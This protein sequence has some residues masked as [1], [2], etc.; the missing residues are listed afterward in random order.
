MAT[1]GVRNAAVASERERAEEQ[2][3]DK[4][5]EER[6]R[7]ETEELLRRARRRK[8][9]TLETASA[10]RSMSMTA[11]SALS[12]CRSS[13]VDPEEAERLRTWR[14]QDDEFK[15]SMR[16]KNNKLRRQRSDLDAE[17]LRTMRQN[18]MVHSSEVGITEQSKAREL[19]YNRPLLEKI[20]AEGFLPELTQTILSRADRSSAQ[21]RRVRPSC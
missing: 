12:Q 4:S 10:N 7:N 8:E 9:W 15:A 14:Q 2:R 11:A 3:V 1:V 19:G 18:M 16:E 20:K 5:C 6:I 13:T 21:K 17:Y